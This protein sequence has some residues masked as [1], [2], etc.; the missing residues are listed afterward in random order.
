MALGREQ[1]MCGGV[2]PSRRNCVNRL[3]EGGRHMVG[4]MN[5]Y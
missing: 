5:G 4:H 2:L 1:G 3:L